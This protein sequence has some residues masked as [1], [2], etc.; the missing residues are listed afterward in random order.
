[1]VQQSVQF[2]QTGSQQCNLR[3]VL[4]SQWTL[5]LLRL[6]T[7]LCL[8]WFPQLGALHTWDCRICRQA[9]VGVGCKDPWIQ[10]EGCVRA[11][12]KPRPPRRLGPRRVALT[13]G[14]AGVATKLTWGSVVGV[15]PTVLHE[16]GTVFSAAASR[17]LL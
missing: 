10:Q 2:V 7:P 13:D 9:H 17:W 1:M 4:S 14:R 11:N 6:Q 12:N 5:L 3:H 15:A 8:C 16:W